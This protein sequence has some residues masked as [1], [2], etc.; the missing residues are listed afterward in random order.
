LLDRATGDV[1]RDEHLDD[2]HRRGL[3][4]ALRSICG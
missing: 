3:D 2:L 4:R 1:E